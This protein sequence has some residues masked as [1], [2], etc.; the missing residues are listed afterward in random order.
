MNKT[1]RMTKTSKIIEINMAIMMLERS[2]FRK[3]RRVR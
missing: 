2:K 3:I 1:G